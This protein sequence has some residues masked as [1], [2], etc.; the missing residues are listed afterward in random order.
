VPE[1]LDVAVGCGEGESARDDPYRSNSVP[2]KW[3]DEDTPIQN[4]R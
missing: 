1:V 4:S 2:A 3:D